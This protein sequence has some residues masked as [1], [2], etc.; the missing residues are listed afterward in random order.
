MPETDN[1]VTYNLKN[2]RYAVATISDTDNSATY[3]APVAWPGAVSIGLDAEG[4]S[5]PFY[6]DGID[7]YTSIANNGY[8]GDFESALV[9]DSFRKEVLG[10]ITDSKNVLFEDADAEPVHFALIFQFDGDANE[11]L[12]VMYNCT[13]ER[14]SVSSSTKEDKISVNKDKIKLTATPIYDAVLKKNI[15]KAKTGAD[16]DATTRASWFTKVFQPAAPTA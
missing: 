11:T 10:E 9:P 13:A 1:K 7:Y 14:P 8:S 16:T 2:V 4:G 5:T 12:H 3:A 15:V 6:A